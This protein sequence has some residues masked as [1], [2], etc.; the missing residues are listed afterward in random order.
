M[1]I[2]HWPKIKSIKRVKPLGNTSPW[3]WVIEPSFG[4]NLK[5]GHCCA[6]LIP[7]ENKQL[8]TYETWCKTFRIINSVSPTVRIDIGGVVGEPTLHPHLTDWLPIA[9]R[10]APF[11]QI[12]ITTNGTMLRSGKVNYK[13]LLDAGAN[14]IYTDQYGPHE[15]F[16]RLAD[17]SGYPS[18]QYYDPPENAWTPW[19]FYGPHIKM[20]VL[21]DHPGTWPE[22][23]FKAGLLGYW[24]GNLNWNKA[25][26]FK[27]TPLDTPLTRRC[28]QPFLFVNVAANGDYLLCCQ[29][30]LH[31][32]AGMFGNISSGISG[33]RQFWY[34]E[35]LQIIRQR[36]RLKNR[37]A[38]PFACQKCNITFSRC[39]FKHWT[40]EQLN[41]YWNGKSWTPMEN[42]IHD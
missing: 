16:E 27:M 22:S 42:T 3:V 8:M 26:R 38:T 37:A 21:M 13:N 12:Q 10:L 31:I 28:N 1:T 19:K 24:Y 11:V 34:G 20:I 35:E 40:P 25:A 6:E 14:I 33:F 2:I 7:E 36:L 32:T 39:D 18:Y 30:G 5:C 23:R 17:E 4:C 15:E 29:D 9:R 41:L